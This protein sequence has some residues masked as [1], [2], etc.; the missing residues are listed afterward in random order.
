LESYDEFG[1]AAH[2]EHVIRG[3]EDLN[4]LREYIDNNPASWQL[5]ANYL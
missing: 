5:D 1:P 2:Y 4:I 3:E